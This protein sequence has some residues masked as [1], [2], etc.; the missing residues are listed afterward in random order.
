MNEDEK[1][2]ADRKKGSAKK[3]IQNK[4]Q[5]HLIKSESDSKFFLKEN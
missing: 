1:G 4:D 2:S 5:V 3:L